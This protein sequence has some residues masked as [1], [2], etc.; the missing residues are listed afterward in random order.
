M[1]RSG[2]TYTRTNG[3]FTG[4]TVWTQDRDAGTKITASNHDTHDQDIAN[5]ITAS[6]AADG[7]TPITSNLPMSGYRHTGCGDGAARTDYCTLKQYQDGT[8]TW[9]TSGGSGAAYTLSLTPAITAY[10]DGA[11]YRFRAHAANTSTTPTI[12]IN[13]L[14][15]KTMTV[16]GGT[17]TIGRMAINSIVILAYNSTTNTMQVMSIM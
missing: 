5:A 4:P 12:N 13:S 10:T 15:G 8:P 7:Q 11:I 3:T 17:I 2:G 14:G 16:N 6:I 9:G 1:G